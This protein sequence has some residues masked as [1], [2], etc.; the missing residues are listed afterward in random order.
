MRIFLVDVNKTKHLDSFLKISKL[1][2][3]GAMSLSLCDM[4]SYHH[5]ILCGFIVADMKYS[6]D[7]CL[8]PVLK[9]YG[10]STDIFGVCRIGEL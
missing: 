4:N 3:M 6:F 8:F 9:L 10:R 2:L 5:E 1:I 7:K